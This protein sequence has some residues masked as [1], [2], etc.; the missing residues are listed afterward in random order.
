[1]LAVRALAHVAQEVRKPRPAAAA[2]AG[3]VPPR[4]DRDPAR[5]VVLA[6]WVAA[7]AEHR[8][9]RP[10]RRRELPAAVAVRDRTVAE[11]VADTGLELRGAQLPADLSAETRG[12]LG[13]AHLA[14]LNASHIAETFSDSV[15][16]ADR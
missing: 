2:V 14:L 6:L 3:R 13:P 9:P 12:V 16:R 8:L 10:V 1:R 5:A 7:T 15:G 4:A 11:R